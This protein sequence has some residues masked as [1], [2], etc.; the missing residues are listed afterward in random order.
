MRVS[1]SCKVGKLGETGAAARVTRERRWHKKLA[2]LTRKDDTGI[3]PTDVSLPPDSPVRSNAEDT[4]DVSI[5]EPAEV[6][7]TRKK[8]KS[9]APKKPAIISKKPPNLA[10]TSTR[11][12]RTDKHDLTDTF[13]QSLSETMQGS[14]WATPISVNDAP[15]IIKRLNRLMTAIR[16][17]A[18]RIPQEES[19]SYNKLEDD[20]TKKFV[21][22]GSKKRTRKRG[23][24][25]KQFRASLNALKNIKAA[26]KVLRLNA[27]WLHMGESSAEFWILG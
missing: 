25:I 15:S 17:S 13:I 5:T 18:L 12:S 10:P 20:I 22:L 8:S 26:N 1:K 6:T 3:N 4:A 11:M 27:K 7:P 2:R 9:R 19:V 24:K 16:R 23:R 14:N 21:K